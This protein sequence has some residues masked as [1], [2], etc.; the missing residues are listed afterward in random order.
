MIPALD[1]DPES[2]F[3]LCGESRFGFGSSKKR[4]HKACQYRS[5][6]SFFIFP[7]FE[8]SPQ[9]DRIPPSCDI[10]VPASAGDQLQHHHRARS[11]EREALPE[12]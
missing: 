3:Q 12:H 7:G 11:R 9:L 8:G 4:N 10:P 5:I 2:D 1:P 6:Q